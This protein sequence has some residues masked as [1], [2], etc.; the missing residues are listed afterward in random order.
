MLIRYSQFLRDLFISA[1]QSSINGLVSLQHDLRPLE[2]LAQR[3]EH[4]GLLS[5]VSAE[6]KT[7]IS[8]EFGMAHRRKMG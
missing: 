2:E 7:I 5:E 6:L 8:G 3:I 1:A 4:Y